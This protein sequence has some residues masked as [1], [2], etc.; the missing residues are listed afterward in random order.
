MQVRTAAVQAISQL[1]IYSREF[2][3]KALEFLI[4]MFNDEQEAVRLCAIESL[5]KIAQSASAR[6]DRHVYFLNLSQ[7]EAAILIV[8]DSSTVCRQS[9]HKMLSFFRIHDRDCLLY[10]A[11]A[12]L[13]NWTRYPQDEK[14][15]LECFA[16]LGRENSLVVGR[17]CTL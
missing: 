7:L 2:G 16:A 10:L 9:A 13:R 17:D 14:T 5:E 3:L 15:I 8:Q 1:S 11:G 12:L 4:D 6:G